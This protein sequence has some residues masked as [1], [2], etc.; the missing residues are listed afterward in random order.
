[1]Q[2]FIAILWAYRIQSYLEVGSRTGSCLSAVAAAMALGTRFVA[3]DKPHG[4][5]KTREALER[6]VQIMRRRGC[7]VSQ[8]IGDSTDPA[9]IEAVRALG[10][11]DAVF[12]DANHTEPYVRHDWKIYGAMAT[13]IC[14]FHDIAFYRKH[15]RPG[16]L[17]IDV[18]RVWNEIKGGYRH[19]EIKLDPTGTDNGI[20]VLFVK[21]PTGAGGYYWHNSINDIEMGGPFA[22]EQDA[23]DA[24]VATY[25]EIQGG[26]AFDIAIMA[27]DGSEAV[28]HI[29][30]GKWIDGEFSETAEE[31]AARLA[32][33]C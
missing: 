25:T 7:D 19:E 20:G 11:F 13:K 27:P 33:S 9:V 5:G 14:A 26:F 28:G 30:G 23:K 22:S 1:M 32:S 16:R 24:A 17:P 3:V 10:P 4:D 8:I 12:I 6:N 15:P 18:P 2:R 31:R 21:D 29:K